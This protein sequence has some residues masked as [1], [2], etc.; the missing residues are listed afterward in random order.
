M[1]WDSNRHI[2]LW[3]ENVEKQTWNVWSKVTE[4]QSCLP[5]IASPEDTTLCHTMKKTA[6]PHQPQTYL[7]ETTAKIFHT[8]MIS[9]RVQ[10][11]IA[12]S[13][14]YVRLCF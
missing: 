3:N 12:L 8:G 2:L 7:K 13:T 9:L 10:H 11:Y 6:F 4:G 5:Y 14:Q 1:H